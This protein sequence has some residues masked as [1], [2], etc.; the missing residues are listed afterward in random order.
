[1]IPNRRRPSNNHTMAATPR[2]PFLWPMLFKPLKAPCTRPPSLSRRTPARRFA[3][4]RRACEESIAQRYGKA[5]EPAPHLR[6]QELATE[7]DDL[8]GRR[9][10]PAEEDEEEEEIPAST[11]LPTPAK[12]IEAEPPEQP[13]SALPPDPPKAPDAKPMETILH[14][15]SPQ[16]QAERRPPH[17][18]TPPY[19]HHFDTYSLVKDL[20]ES[21]F[22]QAQSVTVMKAV[23]DIL[24]DNMEL[25]RD[26]LVSK[27]NIENETYLFRAACSELRTEVDNTRK[28]EVERMRS[29]RNQLQHEVDILSQRM[30]QE[31]THLKDELKGLFDDRKMAVRNEQRH[32]ESQVVYPSLWCFCHIR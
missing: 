13:T 27:S 5:Q 26:G 6:D 9:P 22:S 32:M 30:G 1:M 28:A 24:T 14:M 31:T 21:G 7:A 2:L 8:V 12:R 23:R 25:A 3:T 4:T 20:T 29:E 17:L 10:E 15:P 11:I 18:K 19:V 16:E